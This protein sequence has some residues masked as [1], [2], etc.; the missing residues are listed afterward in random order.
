M[1]NNIDELKKILNLDLTNEEKKMMISHY[2]ENDIAKM[3]DELSVN[4]KEQ[5]YDILGNEGIA[6]VILYSDDVVEI[7]EQL[8][9][10]EA[11]DIIETMDADDA[12]DILEELDEETRNEIVNLLEEEIKEDIET[13]ISYDEDMIGSRMTNNYI[14][15]I[16]TDS[17]KLAMKKI[18][19]QAAENDNVNVIYVVNDDNTLY[20]IIELRDLIIAR[21][22]TSLETIIKKNYPYFIADEKISDCI[23]KLKE[24]ALDS[25]PI[26][27]ENNK[28]IGAIT[29]GDVLEVFDEE[30]GE[31]YAKLAGLNDANEYELSVFQSVKSR[32]PW[33]VILLILGLGQSFLM[34][35]FEV[36]VASLPVI[37][38]FQTLVLGMSGNTGTQSLAVTIR[39][40]STEERKE[41]VSRIIFKEIKVG[42]VNGLVLAVLAMCFVFLF[43]FLTNQGVKE[44]EF[45]VL[46]GI[47]A[48]AIVGSSLLMAMTISSLFGTM[49][50]IIFKKIKIDPAVASGP[51]ITTINDISAMIIYY[52]LAAILFAIAL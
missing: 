35:G 27:N 22:N 7:V 45:N 52:G 29:Q 31:D 28:L 24:Y 36:V 42:F 9:P 18:I 25:Y 50:P 44:A 20:G 48:S 43:L 47:K 38:F 8:T 34:T 16:K 13:I 19:S 6:E 23:I 41:K 26:L 5:L 14:E 39:I 2:H 21:E 40:L 12:V 11:A 3:F 30:L 33:L 32:I 4:E 49:I 51:F 37:V 46:E 1:K 17:V 10:E 15:I